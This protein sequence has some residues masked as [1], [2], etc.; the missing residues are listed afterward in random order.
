VAPAGL[1][2]DVLETLNKAFA[3]V[4]RDPEVLARFRSFGSR[5]MTTDPKEFGD[6]I[7]SEIKKWTAVVDAAHL[8]Q[9]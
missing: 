7:A 3:T 9:K 8:R 2:P 5:P 1:A 4:L 6:F